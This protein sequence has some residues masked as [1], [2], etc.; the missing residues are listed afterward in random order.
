MPARRRRRRLSLRRRPLPQALPIE[1]R[2]PGG[3]PAA[4]QRPATPEAAAAAPLRQ[5]ELPSPA[6]VEAAQLVGAQGGL[7]M[8]P[9]HRRAS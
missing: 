5:L 4:A 9:L 3:E 2:E 7:R 1:L 6:R 8:D